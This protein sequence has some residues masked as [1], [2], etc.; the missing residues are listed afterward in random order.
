MRYNTTGRKQVYTDNLYKL[1]GSA[2]HTSGSGGDG[3]FLFGCFLAFW[4]WAYCTNANMRHIV[5]VLAGMAAVPTGICFVIKLG[6]DAI[7][8]EAERQ[9]AKISK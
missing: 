6:T 4:I 5:H 8:K 3:K 7:K 1:G 2:G 9:N